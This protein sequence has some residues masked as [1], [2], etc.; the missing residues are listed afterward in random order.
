VEGVHLGLGRER[1]QRRS[2]EAA[3]PANADPERPCRRFEGGGGLPAQSEAE[4]DDLPL[5]LPQAT[6][7]LLEALAGECL[8][9]VVGDRGLVGGEQVAERRG[10]IG[11]DGLV[12]TGDDP[13]QEAFVA[14]TG[15]SP[16]MPPRRSASSGRRMARPFDCTARWSDCRIH[17]VA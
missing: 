9:H 5:E 15:S 13:G 3:D 7:G 6:D 14:F 8:D 2:L 1:P 12:E 11:G 16:P 4:S 17:H 10:G